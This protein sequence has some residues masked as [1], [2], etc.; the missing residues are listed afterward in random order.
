MI[1]N[2]PTGFYK[3]ILPPSIGNS[4][5]VT[6]AISG[7]KPP[8]GALY[9][10][11]I[12]GGLAAASPPLVSTAPQGSITSSSLRSNRSNSVVGVAPRPI[13]SVV[14]FT[15]NYKTLN[16][17]TDSLN[18]SV[19]FPKFSDKAT[20]N[21]NLKLL[22]AYQSYQTELMK[23]SQQSLS[24]QIEIENIEISINVAVSSLQATEEALKIMVND[25]DLLLAKI[26]LEQQIILN[27][28]Q[29]VT[30]SNEILSLDYKR[31]SLTDSI[32]KW[33][34]VIK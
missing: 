18:E 17:R 15:D 7:G 22:S 4:M 26:D 32:Q 25:I 31:S 12:G 6:Y 20:D 33:S 29:I 28:Q 1:I 21:L 19:N 9:F 5:N 34:K 24:K 8:R 30:L 13:G 3:S 14:E 2:Y 23:V 27:E 11:K 16:V 10:L